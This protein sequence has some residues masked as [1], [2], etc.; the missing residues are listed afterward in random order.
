MLLFE[1]GW[2]RPLMLKAAQ[3]KVRYMH[4]TARGKKKEKERVFRLTC[5]GGFQMD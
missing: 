5:G 4:Y 1:K 2:E 3:K